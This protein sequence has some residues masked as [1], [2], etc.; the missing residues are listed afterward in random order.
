V[1]L[2]ISGGIKM[3]KRLVVA[4]NWLFLPD[5]EPEG[6]REF[7]KTMDERGQLPSAILTAVQEYCGHDDEIKRIVIYGLN[8]RRESYKI[9]L[10]PEAP[11]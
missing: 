8:D 4:K 7:L 9:V 5:E 6:F 2:G 1:G 11:D 3:R 10:E